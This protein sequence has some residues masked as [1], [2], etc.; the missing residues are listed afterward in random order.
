MAQ[1]LYSGTEIREIRTS[2][3]ESADE[4]FDDP[5][6]IGEQEAWWILEQETTTYHFSNRSQDLRHQVLEGA[7]VEKLSRYVKANRSKERILTRDWL[8]YK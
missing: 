6:H 2:E 7:L 3:E 5:I 4:S 8:A 1:S